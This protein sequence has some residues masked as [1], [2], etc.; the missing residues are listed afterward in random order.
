[1]P[2]E[3]KP[4]VHKVHK[5]FIYGLPIMKKAYLK[6]C[7]FQ[8]I[9]K[10]KQNPSFTDKYQQWFHLSPVVPFLELNK[11]FRGLSISNIWMNVIF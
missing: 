2:R 7:T 10:F 1:M 6:F 9:K 8:S 11:G 5:N 4:K 3:H